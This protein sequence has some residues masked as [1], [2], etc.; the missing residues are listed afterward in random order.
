MEH[1]RLEAYTRLVEEY[2]EALE[3]ELDEAW[4]AS[5]TDGEEWID[6]KHIQATRDRIASA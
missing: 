3:R 2:A 6:G 1:A 5:G 4:N